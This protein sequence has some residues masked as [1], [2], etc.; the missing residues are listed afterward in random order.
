MIIS[1]FNL[2]LHRV[3][4]GSYIQKAGIKWERKDDLQSGM[5]YRENFLLFDNTDLND[6]KK[7][8]FT[9]YFKWVNAFSVIGSF[10]LQIY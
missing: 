3:F 9:K 8:L 2:G 4:K 1:N 6:R 7:C 10:W 5:A